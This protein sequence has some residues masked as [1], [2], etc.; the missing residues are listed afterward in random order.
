MPSGVTKSFRPVADTCHASASGKRGG[1]EGVQPREVIAPL[2][3]VAA[4]AVEVEPRAARDEDALSPAPAVVEALE[5]AAPRA[6]LVDL[7]EH[8]QARRRELAA[9]DPIWAARYRGRAGMGTGHCDFRPRSKIL[10]AIFDEG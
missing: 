2:E 5:E 9:Q 1:G 7:V 3:G 8:P 4:E 6:V 10:A